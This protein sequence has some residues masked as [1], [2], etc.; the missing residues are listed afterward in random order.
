VIA[1]YGGEEF[2]AVLPETDA[3]YALQVAERVRQSIESLQMRH[4]SSSTALVVTVSVGVGTCQASFNL[5]ETSLIS[6]ADQALYQ[7]KHE[8]RNRVC[9]QAMQADQA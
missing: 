3:A 7:A 6:A 2:I 4:E 1:R 9:A 8:G 5:P